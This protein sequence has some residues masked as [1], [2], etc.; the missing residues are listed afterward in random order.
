ME[1]K[2]Q[3]HAPASLFPGKQGIGQAAEGGPQSVNTWRQK[4]KSLLLPLQGI[5]S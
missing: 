2:R 4:E 3:L 5:E 1:M